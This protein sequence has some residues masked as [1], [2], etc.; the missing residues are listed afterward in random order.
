MPRVLRGPVRINYLYYVSEVWS[1]ACY[2][3]AGRVLS[4]AVARKFFSFSND[5][6]STA[7][8]IY[9]M[10]FHAYIGH[11]ALQA[12]YELHS[13]VE[14]RWR[15]STTASKWYLLLFVVDNVLHMPIQVAKTTSTANNMSIMVHH[16][17]SNLCYCVGLASGHMHFW[18]CLAGISE[19][20]NPPLSL[21]LLLKE[22]GWETGA[23]GLWAKRLFKV[24]SLT[25]WLAFFVSKGRVAIRACSAPR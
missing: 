8:N 6:P 10:V 15:G 17:L 12:S 7:D 14:L 13:S 25:V 20:T 4:Y 22:C 5:V 21:V 16:I 11:L 3:V 2:L 9:S 24:A 23:A 18:A 19:L 1:I